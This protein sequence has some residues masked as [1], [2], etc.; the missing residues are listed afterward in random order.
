M[1]ESRWRYSTERELKLW[2]EGEMAAPSQGRQH[3]LQPQDTRETGENLHNKPLAPTRENQTAIKEENRAPINLLA[4][5][6]HLDQKLRS[7]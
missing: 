6:L 1:R 2:P 3:T 7:A 5:I 4:N